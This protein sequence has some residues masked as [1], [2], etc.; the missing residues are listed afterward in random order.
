M[1]FRG[2]PFILRLANDTGQ[3]MP[4]GPCCE[5]VQGAW[6]LKP[7]DYAALYKRW[8]YHSWTG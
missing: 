5:L 3:C 8:T 7:L 6:H 1:L 2:V 4:N